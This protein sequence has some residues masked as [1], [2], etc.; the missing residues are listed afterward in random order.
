MRDRLEMHRIATCFYNPSFSKNL[1]KTVN[2]FNPDIVYL[3]FGYEALK[4][5]DNVDFKSSIIIH[6]RGYDASQ[7]L[8]N[9]AYVRRLKKTL[10]HP[11]IYPVFVSGSLI[12]NLRNR[13]IVFTN[14]PKVIH[15]NTD[16]SFFK[17][18]NYTSPISTFKLVQ[19]STF[20]EKKG[21]EYTLEALKLF[22]KENRETDIHLTFTGERQGTNYEKIKKKVIDDGLMEK[23][24]FAGVLNPDQIRSLLESNHCAVLHSVTTEDGDQEGIPNA[25]MEAMSMEMPVIS[26]NHSGIPELLDQSTFS[27]IVEEKD[28]IFYAKCI[29]NVIGNWRWAPENRER[30]KHEFSNQ[31]FLENMNHLFSEITRI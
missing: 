22:L 15:S 20:R 18:R 13:G 10:K 14:E 25:L 11:K 1:T 28:T 2:D 27:Y 29:E 31:Q 12:Q 4:F 23:V 21:H 16:L 6:F 17:R 8:H 19:V 9:G 3:Q 30:I 5:L 26:T 24:T 7:M